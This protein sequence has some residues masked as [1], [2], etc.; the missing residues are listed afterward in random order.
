MKSI[1]TSAMAI[2]LLIVVISCS[3]SKPKQTAPFKSVNDKPGAPPKTWK[4]HW[5]EHIKTV[6]LVYYDDNVAFYYDDGV[7]KSV[8]W[9]FKA[10]SD[11]WGYVKKTYGAYGDSS[12]LYVIFHQNSYPGGHPASY[13]D[14][15]HDYRNTLD[16]GL[17][18][19]TN[20]TGE[21][22]GMPIHEIGHIVCGASNGVQ[23]APSD[24]IWGDSKF[25][26]IFN[27]D[28]LMNIGREDEAA[29]VYQQMVDKNPY[30]DYPGRKYPGVKW[31]INWFY[32]IY[33]KYG[34]A[35]L[36]NKY[37]KVIAANYPKQ[38]KMYKRDRDMSLGEFVHFWSGAAGAN[39]NEQA[40]FAFGQYW[41]ADVQNDFLQAQK[42][43]PNVKY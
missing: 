27:Y 40:R 16:A 20:P 17:N 28:V 23:G 13:F 9:P 5:F 12:R 31:F 7:D 43:F 25:M 14:A 36:L 6:N 26:E 10:M 41:T 1:F 4:E 32:P 34:K 33:T 11:V 15:S 37:F 19:W 8:T 21:Q 39:L 38:G 35:E 30:E 18:S 42:D 2:S 22:I 29:R 3:C 24:A